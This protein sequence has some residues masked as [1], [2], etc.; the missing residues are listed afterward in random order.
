MKRTPARETSDWRGSGNINL[1]IIA[2][3]SLEGNGR[4]TIKRKVF[5]FLSA[6]ENRKRSVSSLASRDHSEAAWTRGRASER[7][8]SFAF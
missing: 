5:L 8:A 2:D 6:L 4:Q 3:N 1:A 7:L